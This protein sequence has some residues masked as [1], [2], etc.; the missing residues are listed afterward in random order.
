[1]RRS[2]AAGNPGGK[3]VVR[4]GTRYHITF[5]PRCEPDAG[6]KEAH[7]GSFALEKDVVRT[8]RKAR[9]KL[10]RSMSMRRLSRW[11]VVA[12]RD[13]RI[14]DSFMVHLSERMIRTNFRWQSRSETRFLDRY[15][16]AHFSTSSRTI[17][18]SFHN[19]KTF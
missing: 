9:W 15:I 7:R 4:C 5:H 3:T 13:S 12:S 2:F 6:G 17:S 18:S 19:R 16:K 14:G 11:R 10:Q 8:Y 1:M